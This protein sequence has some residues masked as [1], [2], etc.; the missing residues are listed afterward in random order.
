MLLLF[1]RPSIDETRIA[2][3]YNLENTDDIVDGILSNGARKPQNYLDGVI[4]CS[5]SGVILTVAVPK[6][7]KGFT[8]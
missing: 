5:V 6:E 7:Y 8:P 3:W 1:S 4:Y 2:T